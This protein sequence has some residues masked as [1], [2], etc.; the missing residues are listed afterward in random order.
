[1]KYRLVFGLSA[2]PVHVGHVEMVTQSARKLSQRGFQIA[3]VLLVPVFRR[4]PVGVDKKRIPETYHHRL[5]MCALAACDIADR[6][7][8]EHER[9]QAS[10]IE[11]ELARDRSGPNYTAETLTF[12]KMRSAPGT[13]LIFLISSE[14]VSGSAPQFGQWYRP[15]TILKLASLAICPRPGYPPNPDFV[16]GL[17]ASRAQVIVLDEVT[18][19]DI[20]ATD[21]R[22]LLSAGHSPQA[23]AY[24]GLLSP[25]VAGYLASNNFYVADD[26]A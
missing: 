2:D 26:Y 16:R 17:M 1:M 21:L 14:L 23:L 12:L 8:V 3:D 18:T 15:A 9:V 20:A 6:L 11:A 25:S 22:A 19:P 5:M 13:A 7:G 24:Q 4:N 10:A